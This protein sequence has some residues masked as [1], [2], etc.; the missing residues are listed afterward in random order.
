MSN[1]SKNSLK[2]STETN[3]KYIECHIFGFVDFMQYECAKRRYTEDYIKS[4]KSMPY[5]EYL[6]TTHWELL[7]RA[8][9]GR[10]GRRCEICDNSHVEV[11]V[12]HMTYKNRGKEDIDEM[13]CLCDRCHK[14]VHGLL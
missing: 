10:T 3:P 14:K 4:L 11:H 1:T 13:A 2:E 12:H 5:Q 8:V 6:L 9:L 7:K